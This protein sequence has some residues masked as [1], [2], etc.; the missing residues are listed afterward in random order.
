MEK[1]PPKGLVADFL[2]AALEYVQHWQW[3][4]ILPLAWITEESVC[5]CKRGKDCD[6]PGKHPLIKGGFKNASKNESTITKWWKRWRLSNIGI[7]TGWE[8]RLFVLDV[9]PRNGGSESLAKL[10]AQYGELPDTLTCQTGGG[11]L[12]FYFRYPVPARFKGKDK[13]YPGLD[14]KWDGGY[15]VAPPSI[16]YS[17]GV[18]SFKTD[19]RTTT[20]AAPPE[21][22]L[23][24]IRFDEI[25]KGL[26][27]P[28]VKQMGPLPA[29]AE[30]EAG[31]EDWNIF[32]R[33]E[34]GKEASNYHLLT[35]GDWRAAG[36]PTQS[37]AD[38]ALFNKL[39]RLTN[40]D[41]GRMY[42]IFK[43]TGLMRDND[44]KPFSYYQWTIQ[45]AIDD[46]GW[47]PSQDTNGRR[48]RR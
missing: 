33:L 46:M 38:M 44:D 8:S 7:C 41:A 40:G 28:E 42:S 25:P 14:F 4:L 15:V 2:S 47:Q 13:D 9:D 45:K 37:E 19:W 23:E 18:Y 35:E 24:L 31:P 21:W 22:L 6:R 43:E 20:L 5:G 30:V 16:H 10:I 12:H 48:C 11:G 27:K 3:L 39:A 32:R 17:G 1:V 29:W 34:E 36:Y 26:H